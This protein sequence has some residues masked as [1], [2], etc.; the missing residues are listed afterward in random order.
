MPPAAQEEQADSEAAPAVARYLP[1][2]QETQA[3]VP[4]LVLCQRMVGDNVMAG[5]KK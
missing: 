3:E 2:A 5:V 1:E 4:V